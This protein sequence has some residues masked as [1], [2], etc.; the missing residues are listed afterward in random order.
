MCVLRN[1]FKNKD[2]H[3]NSIRGKNLWFGYICVFAWMFWCLM[4]VLSPSAFPLFCGVI[5]F[6]FTF[7]AVFLPNLLVFLRADLPVY[8]SN[9]NPFSGEHFFVGFNKF[10]S[11]VCWCIVIHYHRPQEPTLFQKVRWDLTCVQCNVCIDTGPPVLR[12]I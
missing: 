10:P 5:L 7:V 8:L 2:Y 9:H 12:P 4:Q 11:L 1:K 3:I 6:S